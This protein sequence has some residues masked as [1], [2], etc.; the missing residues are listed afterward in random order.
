MLIPHASSWSEESNGGEKV[1]EDHLALTSLEARA[2]SRPAKRVSGADE[3]VGRI[4]DRLPRDVAVALEVVLLVLLVV[5]LEPHPLR[6]A[7]RREDVRGD[8]IE[9]E[10]VM[11]DND[12][13]A[14][15]LEQRLDRWSGFRVRAWVKWSGSAVSSR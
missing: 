11:A 4:L 10:A 1:S 6:V 13:A 12:H 2:S 9:E 8:A 3:G 15:E 5:A 14:G 7:L